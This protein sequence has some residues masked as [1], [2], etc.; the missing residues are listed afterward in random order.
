MQIELG[1]PIIPA[2]A[3]PVGVAP[4]TALVAGTGGTS[5]VNIRWNLPFV[6]NT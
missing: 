5:M 4:L 1:A 6:S 2:N 3:P